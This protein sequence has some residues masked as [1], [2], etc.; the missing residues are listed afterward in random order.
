MLVAPASL[1]LV[2]ARLRIGLAM[3]RGPWPVRIWER[4]SSKST[5]RTQCRRSS[6]IQWPRMMAASSPG[7]PGRR[8]A[9]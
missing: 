6:I 8:P 2:M 9:R 4:P 1:K 7:W 5:A 3:M